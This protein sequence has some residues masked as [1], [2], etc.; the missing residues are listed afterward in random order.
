MEEGGVGMNGSVV[1]NGGVGRQ[2][3]QKLREAK[4]TG[5]NNYGKK[6][7]G[8]FFQIFGAKKIIIFHQKYWRKIPCPPPCNT[9]PWE[10]KKPGGTLWGVL[11]GGAW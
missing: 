2:W 8:N 1:I 4:I 10:A 3:E 9:P 5:K 7:S 6:I 11:Q